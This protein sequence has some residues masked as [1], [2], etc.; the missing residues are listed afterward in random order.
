MRFFVYRN[1]YLFG[2]CPLVKLPKANLKE[3]YTYLLESHAA[4]YYFGISEGIIYLSYRV[5]LDDLN[6][7]QIESIKKNIVEM[8]VKADDLDNFLV[9]K[10]NCEW[11]VESK[12]DA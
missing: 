5:H 1:S 7:P 4:P 2:T 12:Q 3:L 6:S 10:F 11:S 8:P 9:D